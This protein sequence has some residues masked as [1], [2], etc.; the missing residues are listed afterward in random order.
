MILRDVIA[1]RPAAG[2]AGRIFFSTDEGK[3][4]RDSGSAWGD[5]TDTVSGGVTSSRSIST[6]APLTG[7]GDLTANRTLAISNFTGDSGSGGAKGAV[8]APASGDSAA[9]K[10]LK[11]DG[12][13]AVP[14]GSGS[15]TVN[16]VALTAPSWLS[17]SGSPV[18]TSGTIAVSATTGQ[19]ANQVLAT[20]DGTTGT[21]GLRALVSADI[22]N[23]DT[24]KITTGTMA[25]ARLGSGT[26]DNTTYLR[27]DGTWATPAGSGSGTVSSVAL[28][29]P[30]WLSV[31]GSPVT[32]SG[33]LA[34]TATSGQTANQ[35]LA[36]PNGSTGTVALRS[37]VQADLPAQP[38]DIACCLTGK[39]GASAI[40]LILT[41]TRA[42]AFSGNF[43]GSYGSVGANPTSTATYT[44]LKNGS[45]IGSV[46][47][48]TSGTFTFTTSSG[49]SQS[50][51][52]GDRLTI[53]APSSQDAT[54]SDVGFTLAGTR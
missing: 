3:T 41:A 53:T 48:S 16:S 22:P 52:A 51:A 17:V 21:V 9:G 10:Y 19:T 31:S 30:S 28:T 1:N 20:P 8:P 26:A 44:V 2:I 34:V 11:A 39:P 50:L 5:C 23:L 24:A 32:T 4:Y 14:A 7:G 18:T 47:I 37:I 36:T 38:Y 27:G 40:V 46:A 12:T 42:I 35:F 15:G 45:S 25:S 43:S 33:T 54:L 49:A 29:V 6:T 13:W